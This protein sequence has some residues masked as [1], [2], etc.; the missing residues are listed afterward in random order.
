[1]TP[2]DELKEYFD[3]ILDLMPDKFDSHE[4]ILKLAEKHQPEYV[5]ALYDNRNVS[6]GAIFRE[7]HKQISQSLYDYADSDGDQ[8]SKDIFGN[9]NKNA[10]WKK[11]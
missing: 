7:L 8:R 4:F 1:M 9:R 6:T 3:E 5:Q 2:L 10:G 11:K